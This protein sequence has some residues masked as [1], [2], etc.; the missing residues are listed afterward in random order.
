MNIPVLYAGN[1]KIFC[2]VLLSV[3]S[4]LKYHKDPLT[5]YLYTM[6]LSEVDPRFEP[7]GE[8][9]RDYLEKLCK[10]VNPGSAVHLVDVKSF[11]E[12]TLFHAPNQDNQYTPY[13]FLRLY[14]DRVEG[15]PDKLVYLDTDTMLCGDVEELYKIELGKAE[16]AGVRDRYGCH[17]FG[18]NYINSGVLLLN[19]PRIRATRVFERALEA[20]GKKKIFL[21]DQTTINRLCKKKKILPRRFNDQKEVREDTVVR[22]FSMTILWFPR[23]PKIFTT[24]NIKPWQFEKVHEILQESTFD[25]IF[26]LYQSKS[27][28]IPF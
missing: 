12:K 20:C 6:D 24:R 11:Y 14:A 7:F 28:E 1:R 16:F 17:F 26:A 25:D 18:V 9:Q 13:S 15:M 8:D 2:G 22:H 3:L 27:E 4:M 10:E 21:P 23:F 5:I 19:L